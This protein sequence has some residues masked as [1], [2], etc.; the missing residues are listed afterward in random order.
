MAALNCM[1]AAVCF[2]I[3]C[4]ALNVVHVRAQ[5][6]ERMLL[7]AVASRIVPCCKFIAHVNF[8]VCYIFL[9][10][11]F[12]LCGAIQTDPLARRRE[13]ICNMLIVYCTIL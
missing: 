1:H 4:V 11:Y 3:C 5:G 8:I 2:I 6:S 7:S 13:H 10:F 9:Y 12:Y